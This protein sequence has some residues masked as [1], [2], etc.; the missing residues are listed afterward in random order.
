MNGLRSQEQWGWRV[1]LSFSLEAI[2]AGGYFI[3]MLLGM[4]GVTSSYTIVLAPLIMIVGLVILWSHLESGNR[5]FLV[6]LRPGSSWLARGALIMVLFLFFNVLNIIDLFWVP[7]PL[8]KGISFIG[9]LL[10]LGV[11]IYPSLVLRSVRS[12]PFWT[13]NL[14]WLQFLLSS[15][16]AGVALNIMG[17]IWQ[18]SSGSQYSSV[19]DY[20]L[21]TAILL[22]VLELGCFI[23]E[24]RVQEG[25]KY[26]ISNQVLN[27]EILIGLIGIVIIGLL[28]LF[29]VNLGAIVLFAICSWV[30]VFLIRIY[31][32]NQGV[33]VPVAI[34]KDVPD[35]WK[36]K[37]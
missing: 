21:I 12:I 22:C 29:Y 31:V 18:S 6:F 9:S 35:N 30:I 37:F 15:F 20:L 4:F 3:A 7:V 33:R 1:A 36:P 27:R 8:V 2:S 17:L 11:I 13:S 10:A 5:A 19:L 34:L 14:I 26:Q 16:F 28:A 24:Y 23:F 32:L 25:R